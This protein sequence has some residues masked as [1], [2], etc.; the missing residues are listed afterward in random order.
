ML[1]DG[2]IRHQSHF[3]GYTADD[4]RI[5]FST[6]KSIVSLLVGIAIDD[7]LIKS[8][9]DP[10]TVYL[11]ELKDSG[12]AGATIKHV[13]QMTTAV[14][15][16]GE[17]SGAA[18]MGRDIRGVSARSLAFGAGGLREHPQH[19]RAKP[20]VRHGDSWE[21]LNTNTQTLTVLLERVSGRTVSAYAE[22]KLW[23]KLGAEQPAY[24]LID[25]YQDSGAIEHGWMGLIMTLHDMARIGL[26]V[27]NGG[28]WN[29]QQI[30]SSS[31]V[32][33]STTA[34]NAAVRSL[35]GHRSTHYGYQWWMPEG[36]EGEFMSVGHAGQIIYVNPAHDTVIVQ[37][38][39]DPAW[40][41]GT[42]EEAVAVFRA[43]L[44]P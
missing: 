25:R 3:F 33:A 20:G 8:V 17:D 6:T 24:W 2:S 1:E 42:K 41:P 4:P 11:P 22:E 21:Y 44:A 7:G 29:G 43:M 13:L 39:A 16:P 36:D 12:Y 9:D 5:L 28:Y 15:Y 32:K 19:A 27:E 18:G 38:A 23:R 10:V 26:M 40:G 31:W 35:A 30:V 34:D 37:T 14:H